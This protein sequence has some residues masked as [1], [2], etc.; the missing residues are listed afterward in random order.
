QRVAVWLG[1]RDLAG[2]E[3]RAGAGLVLDHDHG[4]EPGLDLVGDQPAKQVGGAARRIGH[5]HPDVAAGIGVLRRRWS[6]GQ[7]EPAANTHHRLPARH[8]HG[9][10]LRS[11]SALT[12]ANQWRV[13]CDISRAASDKRRP[14]SWPPATARNRWGQ[15]LNENA[16]VIGYFGPA[17]ACPLL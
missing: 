1:A 15:E 16:T 14:N 17:P 2:A 11:E 6:R 12:F 7:H 13:G 10:S 9:A 5:D 3:R 8:A 4:V